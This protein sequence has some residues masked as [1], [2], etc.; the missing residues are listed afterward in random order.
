MDFIYLIFIQ[1][2]QRYNNKMIE[3][4][5]DVLIDGERYKVNEKASKMMKIIEKS[6]S[7]DSNTGVIDLGIYVKKQMFEQILYILKEQNYEIVV[8]PKVNS[9]VTSNFISKPMIT[10][11]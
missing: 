8:A 6:K 10:F 1:K 9:N 2:N 11:L 4:E 7:L 5:I 3:G